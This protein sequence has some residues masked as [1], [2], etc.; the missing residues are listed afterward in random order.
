M[1]CYRC[2]REAPRHIFSVPSF[3]IDKP[4]FTQQE[5]TLCC[6]CYDDFVRWMRDRRIK[7]T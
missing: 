4:P 5:V 2:N 7:T 1:K 6:I 3:S